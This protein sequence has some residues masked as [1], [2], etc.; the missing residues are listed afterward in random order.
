MA[1]FEWQKLSSEMSIRCPFLLDVLLTVMDKSK[2][3]C[4]EIIP[5]LGLCYAILMQTRNKDLSLVQRLNTVLLTN[6]NAKKESKI[7]ILDMIGNHFSDSVVEAV[8]DEKKL[9]GTGDNWD[10]KIHVH[11]MRSTNQN[12]DLHYFASNLIVERVPCQN[13]STTSPRRNISARSQI[14]FFS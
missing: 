7:N 8:K 11:D 14:L 2:E 6:G 9:Q 1:G 10:M 4:I 12:Q 13:L 5:Q 3:E